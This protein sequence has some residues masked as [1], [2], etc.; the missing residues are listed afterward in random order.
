ME[1]L[2]QALQFRELCVQFLD[3][4]L[5]SETCPERERERPQPVESAV[6]SANP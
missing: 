5:E 1:D 4:I 3:S 6:R 2:D